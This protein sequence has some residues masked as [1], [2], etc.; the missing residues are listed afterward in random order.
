ME[1][2]EQEIVLKFANREGPASEF[3]DLDSDTETKAQ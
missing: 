2:F 3:Y 1:I